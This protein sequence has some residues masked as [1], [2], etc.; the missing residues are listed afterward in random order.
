MAAK[1]RQCGFVGDGPTRTAP[2]PPAGSRAPSGLCLK[3]RCWRAGRAACSWASCLATLDHPAVVPDSALLIRWRKSPPPSRAAQAA[4]ACPRTIR[5][6]RCLR[7]GPPA[8][9][10]SQRL[11]ARA[12][13]LGKS[14]PQSAAACLRLRITSPAAVP[15][16]QSALGP[17]AVRPRNAGAAKSTL[18]TVRIWT[19]NR[20]A[21]RASGAL[22]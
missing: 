7:P 8:A 1:L 14:A 19:R 12:R 5:R 9:P 13:P 18:A 20:D 16:K 3:L 4:A 22:F 6:S 2:L 10:V 21:R 11:K 15:H 17:T